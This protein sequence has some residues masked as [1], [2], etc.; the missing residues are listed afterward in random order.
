MS[1]TGSPSVAATAAEMAFGSDMMRA[2][3][4]DKCPEVDL[5]SKK[6]ESAGGPPLFSVHPERVDAR[7]CVGSIRSVMGGSF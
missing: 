1:C 6:V 3:G 7:A 5:Q 4:G 2:D